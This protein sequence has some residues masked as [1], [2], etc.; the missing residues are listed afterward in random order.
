MENLA[1]A[2]IV[3]LSSLC[4]TFNTEM[5]SYTQRN[6]KFETHDGMLMI[7]SGMFQAHAGII[8]NVLK[9]YKYPVA[10][11]NKGRKANPAE[12]QEIA[13]ILIPQE[14]AANI[15]RKSLDNDTVTLLSAFDAARLVHQ[16]SGSNVSQDTC[17][18]LAIRNNV[19]AT[20]VSPEIF[21]YQIQHKNI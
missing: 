9:E 2:G 1:D 8:T 13:G 11:T 20:L 12:K 3:N 17:I 10:I 18:D 6:P 21:R 7:S 14:Q 4:E 5:F 16:A 15:E 19:T